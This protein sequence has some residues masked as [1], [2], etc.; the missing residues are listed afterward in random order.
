MSA[1]QAP[2]AR[3]IRTSDESARQRDR[4]RTIAA[5]RRQSAQRAR[6]ERPRVVLVDGS[7]VAHSSEG[8]QRAPGEHHRGVRQAARGGLRAAW[9]SWTPRSVTRST[10]ARRTS[11]WSTTGHIRQAP[12]GTDADYF[13]L[14]FARELDAV[15]RVERPVPRPAEGLSRRGAPADPVHGGEGRGRPRATDRPPR[16]LAARAEP[17]TRP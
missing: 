10:T 2:G 12:A 16:R 13:I 6:C 4:W 5:S 14:S 17:S 8:E 9:S 3:C 11:G 1:R 7:N 15:D